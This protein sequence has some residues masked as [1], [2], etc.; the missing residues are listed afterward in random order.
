MPENTERKCQHCGATWDTVV[1]LV[2]VGGAG[3]VPTR[4]CRDLAD[5][6]ARWNRA[7]GYVFDPLDGLH[8][9]ELVG[10]RAR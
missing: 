8:P 4:G 7:H 1:R 6:E 10:G 3:Y 9:L 5:C 2:Y